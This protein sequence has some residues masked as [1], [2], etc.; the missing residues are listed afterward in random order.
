MQ[1]R[2]AETVCRRITART[3]AASA[4]SAASA[5]STASATSVA[6]AARGLVATQHCSRVGHQHYSRPAAASAVEA[7]PQTLTA[8]TCRR[9]RA[10]PLPPPLPLPPLPL[11]PLPLLQ[12]LTSAGARVTRARPCACHCARCRHR[13]HF[14]ASDGR[15]CRAAPRCRSLPRA[16]RRML[17]TSPLL[18]TPSLAPQVSQRALL[19]SRRSTTVR[20]RSLA[21]LSMLWSDATRR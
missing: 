1:Q 19:A 15:S 10:V 5:R 12:P 8:A 14:P 21:L 6:E 3:S 20:A 16:R 4:A 17:S 7:A 9:D 11:P 13:S 18:L 2:A